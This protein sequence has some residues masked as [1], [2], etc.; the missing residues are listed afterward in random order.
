MDWTF[1]TILVVP[2]VRKKIILRTDFLMMVV[3][4]GG[5]SIDLVGEALERFLLKWTLVLHF[6]I[7]EYG[8]ILPYVVYYYTVTPFTLH[9][10]IQSRH[11]CPHVYKDPGIALIL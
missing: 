5:S 9:S 6:Y 7:Y 1:V 10:S 2:V 3:T 4:E 8:H 11:T